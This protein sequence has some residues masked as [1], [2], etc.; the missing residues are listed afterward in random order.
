M[1]TTNWTDAKARRD[2]SDDRRHG[3]EHAACAISSLSPTP[4]NSSA[5]TELRTDWLLR[6][7]SQMRSFVAAAMVPAS[8]SSRGEAGMV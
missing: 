4:N 2:D 6:V 5:R 3:Y 7:G 1:S 8:R